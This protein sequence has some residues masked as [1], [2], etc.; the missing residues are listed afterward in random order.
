MSV[1]PVWNPTAT[2]Y[3]PKPVSNEWLTFPMPLLEMHS[4]RRRGA[5]PPPLGLPWSLLS[6]GKEPGQSTA[7]QVGSPGQGGWLKG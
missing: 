5:R 7:F 3:A 4:D 2:A 1:R 6:M